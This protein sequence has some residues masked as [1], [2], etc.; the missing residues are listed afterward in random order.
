M[1]STTIPVGDNFS[2]SLGMGV[3]WE[4]NGFILGVNASVVYSDGNFSIGAGIGASKNHWGWSAAATYKGWGGGYG[5]TYYSS[6]EVM[7]QKFGDQKVGTFTASFNH[8]SFSIAF[9]YSGLESVVI[10]ES[11]KEIGEWAFGLCNLKEVIV[12]DNVTIIGEAA[13]AQMRSL[14]QVTLR[15]NIQKVGFGTFL[16]SNL[17][18]LN[19]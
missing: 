1:P 3:G 11:V 9:H 2:V 19:C 16:F 12:P 18:V 14:E 6:S 17:K 10:G 8:N 5:R 7:V 4:T 15:L 13:F